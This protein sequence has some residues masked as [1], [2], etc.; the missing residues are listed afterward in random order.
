[1]KNKTK[2]QTNIFLSRERRKLPFV[3]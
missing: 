2:Y 3:S 1:M